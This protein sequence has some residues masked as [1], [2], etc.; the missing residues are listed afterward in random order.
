[1][2]TSYP[3]LRKI[4]DCVLLSLIE[5]VSICSSNN[6]KLQILKDYLMRY[7]EKMSMTESIT[8]IKHENDGCDTI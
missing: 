5:K 3:G 4:E 8:V 6:S 1:M 2:T 7:T